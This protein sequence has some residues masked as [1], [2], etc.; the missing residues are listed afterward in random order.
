MTAF[1]YLSYIADKNKYKISHLQLGLSN[2]TLKPTLYNFDSEN[3]MLELTNPIKS[4]YPIKFHI[5]P[6]FE[7]GITTWTNTNE[8]GSDNFIADTGWLTTDYIIPANTYFMFVILEFKR[9]SNC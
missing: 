7:Y 6:G 9:G 5:T 8:Q 1:G 4:A 3:I 2:F